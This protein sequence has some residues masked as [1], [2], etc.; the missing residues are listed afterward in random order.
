MFTYRQCNRTRCPICCE[1]PEIFDPICWQ[2]RRWAEVEEPEWRWRHFH[3]PKTCCLWRTGKEREK[4]KQRKRAKELCWKLVSRGFRRS[5]IA[6]TASN[7]STEF[8]LE[9]KLEIDVDQKRKKQVSECVPSKWCEQMNA[10]IR[11]IRRTKRWWTRFQVGFVTVY[12]SMMS[13]C[14]VRTH[15]IRLI[16]CVGISRIQSLDKNFEAT[17]KGYTDKVDQIG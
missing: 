11:R 1:W 2:C 12:F 6:V 4:K 16:E 7:R 17:K 10:L 13:S 9:F 15:S 3:E 8:F 14:K 5:K